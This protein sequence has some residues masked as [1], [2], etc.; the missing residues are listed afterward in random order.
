MRKKEKNVLLWT[1]PSCA[2]CMLNIGYSAL[3]KSSKD[4]K[5]Q[6]QCMEE[7]FSILKD[8]SNDVFPVDLSIKIFRM[9]QNSTNNI[10][11]YEK[12][13][14]L[15]N[16]LG[17]TVSESIKLDINNSN[18]FSE[19]INKAIIGTIVGNIIDFSTAQHKFNL[20]VKEFEDL[21]SQNL[22]TGFKINDFEEF[23]SLLDKIETI[24][25]LLDNA[26]EIA[27]DKLL[28]DELLAIGKTVIVVLKEGPIANDATLEDAHQVGLDTLDV[29]L[30]TTG[31]NALGV[32]F[33]EV[34]KD[35]IQKL[36]S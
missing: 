29:E 36:E 32:M 26:G 7:I 25:Y 3:K 14:K 1:K 22:E 10:D 12:E 15:S 35:F 5:L 30:I 9:L 27:F 18:S 28:I 17:K 2:S 24:L 11:P 19:R 6:Y 20:D 34:S 21:Y 31:S 4:R 33:N 16:K 8:F 13:K 23:I